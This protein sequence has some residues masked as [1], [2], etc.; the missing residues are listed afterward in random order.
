MS[1]IAE[2]LTMHPFRRVQDLDPDDRLGFFLGLA[3]VLPIA[4]EEALAR[5]RQLRLRIASR[6]GTLDPLWLA[7]A[8]DRVRREIR[9]FPAD[10]APDGSD[11][12]HV[13]TPLDDVR[14]VTVYEV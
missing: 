3:H 6:H 7:I 5:R 12:P 4:Q 14:E 2:L 13:D 8:V 11:P 9:V 10:K 1:R